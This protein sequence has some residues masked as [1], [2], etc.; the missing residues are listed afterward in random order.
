MHLFRLII[1]KNQIFVHLKNG[2]SGIMIDK[3]QSVMKNRFRNK[4]IGIIN[5]FK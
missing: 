2:V 5:L 3:I 4:N 1:G